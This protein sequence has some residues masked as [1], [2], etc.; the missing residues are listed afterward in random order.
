[1]SG[2]LLLYTVF[3]SNQLY[4]VQPGTVTLFDGTTRT[5][6]ALELATAYGVQDEPYLTVNSD[7]DLPRNPLER[8]RYI[9]LSPR[10]D[11]KYQDIMYTAEDDGED[12]AY[13]PDFDGTKKY[14]QETDRHNVEP[15]IPEI[16][17]SRGRTGT[18]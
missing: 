10:A 3:M 13:R 5:F 15:D 16:Y 18:F 9:V 6:T 4:A 12:T 1:M 8:M 2:P 14:I 11:N 7:L 17:E